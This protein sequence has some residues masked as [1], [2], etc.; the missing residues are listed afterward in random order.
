MLFCNCAK[1][2]KKSSNWIWDNDSSSTTE[3]TIKPRYIWI[4]A[5][6]NFPEYANS[7]DNIVRDLTK[8]KN[9]GFTDIV[10]DV[11]PTMGDVLYQ[12]TYIKQV[13]KLD[14]WDN[15]TYK[16]YERTSTWDYLQEFID[17]GHSLGLKV[18]A[19]F[20]TFV[21]GNLYYPQGELNGKSQ[22]LL[23]RDNT[24]KS[25]ATVLN[26]SSGLTNVM[27]LD[28]S[29]DPKYEH[30][31]RFLNPANDEVQ[32]FIL[33][34]LGDLAKYD[35]DGIFLDRCRYEDLRGDFSDISK[36]KFEKY[37]NEKITNFP[38]DILA[39]G[40][41]SLPDSKPVYFKKWLE[42]RAKVIHDFIVKARNKIKSVNSNIN[43]GVYVGAWYS[44]YYEVGVNWAGPSYDTAAHYPEWA[45]K[46][47]KN[48]GF[49][50]HLDFILLGAYA[51]ADAIY[52]TSEWTMQGFCKQAKKILNSSVK[53]ASGPDVGNASGFENGNQD[54]V[55]EKSVNACINASDGYF[56]FDIVHVRE[57]NYWD[58][59]KTGIDS[60]L[61][62]IKKNKIVK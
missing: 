33:N 16:Y 52:G 28:V 41:I 24:K 44:T 13:R 49:A 1:N 51:P 23:F 12:T 39:P 3:T 15:S 25:W 30:S 31:T 45:S 60:Y 26:L 61:N 38:S 58:A 11:R 10:V 56:I 21:G 54:T 48:Y 19:A 34:L 35:L 55:V 2:E 20:N 47:Y 4:D 14:Y 59:L 8:V 17:V 36:I 43:F 6:A 53:F 42:F 29:T 62:A 32:K 50:D 5:C 18:N 57:Y 40:T 46:N 9:A 37:I 27:D 22:G 7:K